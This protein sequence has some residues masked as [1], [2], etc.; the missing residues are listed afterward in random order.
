[1]PAVDHAGLIGPN[2]ADISGAVTQSV[3]AT[4]TKNAPFW[5]TWLSDSIGNFFENALFTCYGWVGSS[6]IP[7]PDFA[8]SG[9]YS[10]LNGVGMSQAVSTVQ[11]LTNV[12][13][14]IG[15]IV[16]FISFTVHVGSMSLD[17]SKHNLTILTILRLV[18]PLIVLFAWPTIVSFSANFVTSLGYY[19]FDQ[20]Q[21]ASKGVFNGLDALSSNYLN[22]NS[23]NG[24]SQTAGV[25]NK[26]AMISGFTSVQDV[27]WGF[28]LFLSS[29]GLIFG[30]WKMRNG[31]DWGAKIAGGAGACLL[32]VFFTPLV[33]TLFVKGQNVNIESLGAPNNKYTNNITVK[34]GS[35]FSTQGV[36]PANP[37]LPS[38]LPPDQNSTYTVQ[39][40]APATQTPPFDP[41]AAQVPIPI[42]P[43]NIL[44]D[45][46]NNLLKIFI[47]IFGVI[48][49]VTVLLAKMYQV[50]SIF[51]M[52]FLGFVF[53]GLLGH[54]STQTISLSGLKLFLKLH[55]YTPI[56]ALMLL[57]MHLIIHVQLGQD[58]A[59][60]AIMTVFATLA[61]LQLIQHTSDFAAIFAN[62]H[63]RAGDSGAMEKA[64]RTGAGV[65]AL[66]TAPAVQG[67]ISNL[68]SGGL[69]S[70]A[71]RAGLSSGTA[72]AIASVA[73]KT[74]A[75]PLKALHMVSNTLSGNKAGGIHSALGMGG[76]AGGGSGSGGSGGGSNMSGLNKVA[77]SINSGGA[78][79]DFTKG[80]WPTQ[81]GYANINQKLGTNFNPTQLNSPK[82]YAQR[83][84]QWRQSVSGND[85]EWLNNYDR[86]N[87]DHQ[88]YSQKRWKDI[89]DNQGKDA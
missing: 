75:A 28:A 27:A 16:L 7:I 73:G 48:T 77:G 89:L 5:F 55:L 29:M 79:V 54:P 63:W 81:Q 21:L 83:D 86:S 23:A 82:E 1:M 14:W 65:T 67:A 60:S 3:N 71:G 53:I 68:A 80:G 45:Q 50:V 17:I 43:A 69:G 13:L 26:T 56:W 11:N 46:A 78:K 36:I 8:H 38:G 52:Y 39:L 66:A 74:V 62:F 34:N 35:T 51:V 31:D 12:F 40:N 47:C 18:I 57:I 72:G 22:G 30:F 6:L 85:N 2:A 9:T 19:I 64:V 87:P 42:T 20:N 10:A 24:L 25:N 4:V 44:V 37:S 49:I 84:A 61:A 41:N 59:L 76:G 32:I 88:N 58:G 15:F 33:M 70:L